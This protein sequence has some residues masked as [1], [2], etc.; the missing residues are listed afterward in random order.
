MIQ[1]PNSIKKYTDEN[2][3]QI[4]GVDYIKK[5][6]YHGALEKIFSKIK[7]E[8][9]KISDSYNF[10]DEPEEADI[11]KIFENNELAEDIIEKLT[12]I[13]KTLW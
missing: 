10:I 8:I 3:V 4:E 2:T 5:T 1:N 12:E 6:V 7:S 11:I 9:I 13:K